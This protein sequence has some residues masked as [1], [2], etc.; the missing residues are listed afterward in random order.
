MDGEHGVMGSRRVGREVFARSERASCAPL[1]W[2]PTS[3]GASPRPR[4]RHQHSECQKS[5][6]HFSLDKKMCLL[7]HGVIICKKLLDCNNY[8]LSVKCCIFIV[9]LSHAAVL[10]FVGK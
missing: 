6:D 7:H 4:W 3:E 1:P 8:M 5:G 2:W 9:S 10:H